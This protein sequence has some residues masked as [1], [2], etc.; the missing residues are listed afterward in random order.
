MK[1]RV[2]GL[3]TAS[4]SFPSASLPVAAYSSKKQ[5]DVM[6]KIGNRRSGLFCGKEWSGRL[7]KAY[8]GLDLDGWDRDEEAR[9]GLQ[10]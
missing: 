7:H 3:E 10:L 4:L 6:V 9:G 8:R 2:E 5:E 1:K